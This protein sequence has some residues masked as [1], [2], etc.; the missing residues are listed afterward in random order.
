MEYFLFRQG[1]TNL[2]I[3]IDFQTGLF[4]II[5]TITVIQAPSP[6]MATGVSAGSQ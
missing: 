4:Y 1:I 2:E 3:S 5:L 6:H